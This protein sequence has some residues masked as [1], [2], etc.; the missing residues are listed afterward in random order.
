MALSGRVCAFRSETYG[1]IQP[2]DGSGR[3]FFHKKHTTDYERIQL[4]TKVLFDVKWS[5][6]KDSF[7][8]A[9]VQICKPWQ[10]PRQEPPAAEPEPVK[11]EA[12]PV[13]QPVPQVEPPAAVAAELGP[14]VVAD[15]ASETRSRSPSWA[16]GRHGAASG[17]TAGS[18]EAT[19]PLAKAVGQ[20]RP[21]PRRCKLAP[22]C[23]R[24]CRKQAAAAA[25]TPSAAPNNAEASGTLDTD[26]PPGPAT[27]SELSD[28]FLCELHVKAGQRMSSS[29]SVWRP[30]SKHMPKKMPYVPGRFPPKAAPR[31]S[32]RLTPDVIDLTQDFVARSAES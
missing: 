20:P 19:G 4:G 9:N 1:F 26:I 6:R 15:S 28:D 29:S 22:V 2:D 14:E 17:T 13:A 32:R 23:K 30:T 10:V 7:R 27:A 21:R 18:A 5:D 31:L 25:P 8:A 16:S 12:E 11:P 3:L 24:H